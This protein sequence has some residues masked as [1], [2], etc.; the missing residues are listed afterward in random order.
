[1]GYTTRKF[2]AEVIDGKTLATGTV[3]GEIEAPDY[4]QPWAADRAARDMVRAKVARDGQRAT[5]V[6]ID[7][8]N[9][10]WWD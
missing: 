10:P 5:S 3:E 1:V 9:V 2:K 6:E 8:K 7:G 4:S